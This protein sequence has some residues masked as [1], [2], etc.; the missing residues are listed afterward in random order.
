MALKRVC[1][2]CG[3]RPG[4]RAE[5]V[6]AAKALGAELARRGLGLV[7]GGASVGVMGALADSVLEHGGEVIGV[8]PQALKDKEIAHPRLTEL[9]V[10]G[11]MHERK[12]KM[13]RLAD[14]FIALPGGYGTFEELFE[15][16]TWAQLGLHHKPVAVLNVAGYFDG[17]RHQIHRSVAE[18]FIPE[19]HAD[20]L[21][22]HADP[23]GLVEVL[24]GWRP[25]VIGPKWI[26]KGQT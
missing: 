10:V 5:Y 21:L 6:L 22:F 14:G 13:E 1:V 2:Y 18:G 24:M 7:Y 17:I 20:L 25:P 4:A 16:I 19:S 11:S 3:S 12:A 26:G 23:V 8:M 9:H 15:M